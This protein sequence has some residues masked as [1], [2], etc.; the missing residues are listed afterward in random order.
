MKV[1]ATY[2]TISKSA[3]SPAGMSSGYLAG[4]GSDLLHFTVTNGNSSNPINLNTIT[5]TPTYSG[6]L[7]S[8]STQ[9]INI[10]NA[11]DLNTVIGTGTL[12][13]SGAKVKITFSSDE[14]INS[15]ESYVVKAD[16]SGLTADGNSIRLSLTS[17]D[18]STTLGSAG[19]GDWSWNDSTVSNY[20]NGYLVKNLP[21]D[22]NTMVK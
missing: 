19:A 15:S 9:A 6:T 2:P 22:G 7:T 3:D 17:S 12:G 11:K 16:T 21:V 13:V 10:Y 8:T 14:V 5:V 20:A 4:A 1:V 18:S